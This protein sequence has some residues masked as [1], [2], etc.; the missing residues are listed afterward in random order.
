MQ[1]NALRVCGAGLFIHLPLTA[2]RLCL[3][4]RTP[5]DTGIARRTYGA[6][7]ESAAFCTPVCRRHTTPP[8]RE[9]NKPSQNG[10]APRGPQASSL[11][12]LMR[13]STS[14][15]EP[16]SQARWRGGRRK[17]CCGATPSRIPCLPRR[18]CEGRY[19]VRATPRWRRLVNIRCRESKEG[20]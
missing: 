1:A 9:Q 15:S 20:F 3:R 11:D 10:D 8:P 5:G 7:F 16:A 17:G 4:A 13:L 2:S 14:P 12:T 6:V 19:R 18:R